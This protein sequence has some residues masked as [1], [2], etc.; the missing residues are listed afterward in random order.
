MLPS[1]GL[2]VSKLA[3][4]TIMHWDEIRELHAMGMD[5]QSHT[6]TH[7]A[8]HT[9]PHGDLVGEL[10]GAKTD[11]ERELGSPVHAIS[12]PIGRS[13]AALAP[14]QQALEDAGYELGFTNGTG[15]HLL[16]GTSNRFDIPRIAME[17]DYTGAFFRGIMA[18]PQLGYGE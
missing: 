5:V 13:N 18:V 4:E 7:R 6:R 14:V 11:L 2:K 3:D 1:Q 12:Y 15:P 10:T 17:P 9:V 8:L 16:W